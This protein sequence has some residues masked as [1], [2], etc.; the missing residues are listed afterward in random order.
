MSLGISVDVTLA[1]A[2]SAAV[3]IAQVNSMMPR[4][5]GDTFLHID[6]VDFLLR[7]DEPL[8]EFHASVPGLLLLSMAAGFGEEAN[9]GAI[10]DALEQGGFARESIDKVMGGNF[11]RVWETVTR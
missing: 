5:L 11:V 8:L 2:R 1:A 3:V 10:V 9:F 7:K 4:I 6:Q